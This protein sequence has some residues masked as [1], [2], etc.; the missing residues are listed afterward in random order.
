MS[1]RP[2]SVSVVIGSHDYARF[3]GR[4]IASALDQRDTDVEVVVVDDGSTD[5]S[6]AVIRSFGDDVVAVMKTNGGQGSVYNAG[7]V[8]ASGDVILFLDADDV[9][10]PHA[11]RSVLDAFRRRRDAAHVHF[12]LQFIDGD[13][14]PLSQWNP[15]LHHRLADGDLRR[16]VARFRGYTTSAGSGHAYPRW[17]LDQVLPVPV[18]V[19]RH[20]ADAY[21]VQ[22]SALWGPVVAIE[23]VGALYRLHGANQYLR[24]T[25]LDLPLIRRKLIQS[26]AGHARLREL[27]LAAGVDRY[28]EAVEGFL[29]PLLLTWRMIS[30]RLDPDQHP[31]VTDGRWSLAWRGA[32]SALTYPDRELHRR[33]LTA[34]WFASMAVAGPRAARSL[35]AAFV[36]PERR[37]RIG[38]A[39]ARLRRGRRSAAATGTPHDDVSTAGS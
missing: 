17:L 5:G 27:A 16:H 19:Y 30:A 33:V 3:V 26:R 35:A 18:T 38:S 13:D 36:Y 15:P 11:A 9:L 22:A 39:L 8:A 25:E 6:D 21:L 34:A 14:V 20:G 23:D 7:V 31:M 29:D 2:P 37:G 12:R 32:T 24:A 1:G 4:A 10:L 28:P